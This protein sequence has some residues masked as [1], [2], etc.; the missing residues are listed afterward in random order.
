VPPNDFIP[1]AEETG[2]IVS[3]GEW[4]LEQA[5]RQT[6]EWRKKMA[7]DMRIA[8]NL[9]ARQF[10]DEHLL[11]I[12]KNIL[13]RTGLPPHALDLEITET[14]LMGDSEKLMP[15]FDAL[16]TM[17]VSFSVDDFGIG[18]SSLSYLQRFPIENLKVDRSFIN[19]F[20]ENRD[21]VA[22]TQA[23]IAMAQALDMRVIAEGV[24][25]ESQV[26][27]LR[28]AGCHEMQGFYFSKPVSPEDFETLLH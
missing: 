8:V 17:G 27:F 7:P 25:Q 26:E 16:T 12:V 19:G 21:S 20:P 18:Y 28:R 3:I 5:C 4:V 9:S 10:Q 23:I 6:M 1:V 15:V 13:Q 14:L 22:L 11:T 24:E 2:L